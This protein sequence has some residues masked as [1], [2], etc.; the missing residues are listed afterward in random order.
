VGVAEV[1]RVG[2]GV[3]VAGVGFRFVAW[4]VGVAAGGRV[5]AGIDHIHHTTPAR[6]L[7]AAM[8]AQMAA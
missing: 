8:R 7:M 1:T 5:G 4:S 6:R 3:G 2:A